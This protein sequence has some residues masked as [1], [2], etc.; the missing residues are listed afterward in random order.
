[1]AKSHTYLVSFNRAER[2]ER[3]FYRVFF[4]IGTASVNHEVSASS[5]DELEREVNRLA[6]DYGKTCSPY[7]RLKDKNARA[8]NGF[9]NWKPNWIIDV[10]DLNLSAKD[11]MQ[12]AVAAG[13]ASVFDLLVSDR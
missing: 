11:K 3:G 7:V 2:N 10:A 13:E 12:R 6:V 5:F 9:K 4:D 8:P 1:M